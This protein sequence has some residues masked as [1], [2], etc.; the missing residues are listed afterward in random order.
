MGKMMSL[1]TFICAGF[2]IRMPLLWHWFWECQNGMSEFLSVPGTSDSGT[3]YGLASGW[4]GGGGAGRG[5]G[6]WFA[7][8]RRSW[9]L[10]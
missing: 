10:S 9:L 7:T 1:I 5:G 8:R 3:L 4:R 2:Q 6:A